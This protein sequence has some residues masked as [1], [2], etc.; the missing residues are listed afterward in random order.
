V[1]ES[2]GAVT[3]A[4]VVC[5]YQRAENLRICLE[6]LY[7]LD[8]SPDELVVV[9]ASTDSATEELVRREFPEVRYV[10]NDAG[11]GTLSTS[12]QIALSVTTSD[13]I[14]FLDDDAYADPAWLDEIV[15]PYA[16]P[17]VGGVGGRASNGVPGEESEG[18]GQIGMLLPNGSMTGHFGAD[19][20]RAVAVDHLLG[21][22]MSYRRSSLDCAGGIRDYYP[23]TCLRE[24]SDTALRIRRAGFE[25]IFTPTAVVR[26]VAGPYHAGRRFDLRYDYYA[27]RNH[28][29]LLASTHHWR[30]LRAFV[31]HVAGLMGR[32]LKDAA[33]RA[34][35]QRRSAPKTA[36]RAAVGAPARSVVGVA[37][38]CS[39]AVAAAKA[40]SR[41]RERARRDADK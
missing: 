29:V 16:D 31:P 34:V 12:R 30:E 1:R 10:H 4:V 17:A 15:K 32:D 41:E 27:H 18:A 22:N 3:V 20:G 24:D 25:L 37:G 8:R 13:V 2:N 14:A 11:L 23:G 39:G 33:R 7:Q 19:P 21:A 5:T 38:L 28:V 26:H 9:D 6:H 35:E 40:L 36:L